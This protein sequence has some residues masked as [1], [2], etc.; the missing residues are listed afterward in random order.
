MASL[1]MT[2]QSQFVDGTYTNKW[3]SPTGEAIAYILTLQNDNTFIFYLTRTYLN[4]EP[5]K[6]IKAEGTWILTNNL[7]ILKTT[8]E[9]TTDSVLT[10]DLHNN[11]AR[12]MSISP[13][14][15]SF[16]L[17]QPSFKFYQSNV[18]YAKN[19]EL[20]KTDLNTITAK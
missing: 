15:P 20:F 18:F 6:T 3:E 19:M 2:I 7:L 17:V 8:A 5:D 13:R 10:T 9:T 1:T 11:K 14:N 12:Y 16:N 4:Q